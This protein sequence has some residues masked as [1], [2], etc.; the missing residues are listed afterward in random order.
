[1]RRHARIFQFCRKCT[2]DEGIRYRKLTIY[3]TDHY[4][5]LITSPAKMHCK[6]FIFLVKLASC[7]IIV[8]ANLC[9]MDW[10][11]HAAFGKPDPPLE[12]IAGYEAQQEARA[13]YVA[14]AI[15]GVFICALYVYSCLASCCAS[16]SDSLYRSK[17]L[18]QPESVNLTVDDNCAEDRL[19]ASG[20]LNDAKQASI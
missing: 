3:D 9:L 12:D 7:V 19:D 16:D 1:M 8:A 20:I 18:S 10:A 14:I 13:K 6:V 11:E 5:S 2:T 4:K 15:I 17:N